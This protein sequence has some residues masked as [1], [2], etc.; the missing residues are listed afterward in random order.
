MITC[1]VIT[2]NRIQY[3]CRSL[4]YHVTY[5]H[6]KGLIHQASGHK[7][8]HCVETDVI[9]KHIQPLYCQTTFPR[10]CLCQRDQDNFSLFVKPF[11][12]LFCQINKVLEFSGNLFNYASPECLRFQ[13]WS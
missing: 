5:C 4:M 10:S 13:S 8:S 11:K 7:W 2:K 3:K 12:C 1:L 9:G 6:M